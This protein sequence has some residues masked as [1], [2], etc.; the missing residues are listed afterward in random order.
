[1]NV[2]LEVIGDRLPKVRRGV[3][4]DAA[5]AGERIGQ[6]FSDMTNDE[7]QR[8]QAVEEARNDE[9]QGMKSGLSVPAPARDGEK[10]A[11][12]TGKAGIISVADRLGRRRGVEVDG[13]TKMSRSL[14]DREEARIVKKQTTGCA[15]EE[16][17][18]EAEAGDAALQL[19]RCRG[20]SLQSKRGKPAEWLIIKSTVKT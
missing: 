7:L 11:E 14:K 17:A 4:E 19:R 1:M 2:G 20:G 9:A 16:S 10:E 8:R 5:A 13:N 12:F 6:T 18:V 3:R 15:I